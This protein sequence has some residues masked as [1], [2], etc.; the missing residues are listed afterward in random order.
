M[1]SNESW[2]TKIRSYLSNFTHWSSYWRKEKISDNYEG[3]DSYKNESFCSED[4]MVSEGS[5]DEIDEN[6]SQQVISPRLKQKE[7]RQK[8]RSYYDAGISA[9]VITKDIPGLIPKTIYNHYKLFNEK[10]TNSRKKGS[11][12]KL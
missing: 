7:I 10:M 11:E 2:L 8:L 1:I 12:K 6:Q 5:K 9:E 3:S 4:D